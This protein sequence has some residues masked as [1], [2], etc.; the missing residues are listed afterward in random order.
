MCQTDNQ[1]HGQIKEHHHFKYAQCQISAQ[2][3]SGIVRLVESAV[4]PP[5][6]FTKARN[7]VGQPRALALLPHEG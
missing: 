1:C 4:K 2:P 6:R 3:G 7:G 5:H